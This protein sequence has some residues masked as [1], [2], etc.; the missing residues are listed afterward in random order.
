MS[1]MNK[2]RIV[3]TKDGWRLSWEPGQDEDHPSAVEALSAVRERD[4]VLAEAG[5]VVITVIEWE[6][7]TR[8]GRAA[9]RVLQE[10]PYR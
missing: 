10:Q 4:R 9:V 6:P 5:T 2:V 7:N 1:R 3:E 8:I